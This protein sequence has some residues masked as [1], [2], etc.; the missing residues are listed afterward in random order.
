M[1]LNPKNFLYPSLLK[2]KSTVFQKSDI[3]QK[4][5]ENSV[6]SFHI[7][8]FENDKHLNID[9]ITFRAK[10]YWGEIDRFC[11]CRAVPCRKSRAVP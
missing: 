10:V 4:P 11:L 1:L 2:A 7:D 6:P 5:L 8:S 9:T 3:H